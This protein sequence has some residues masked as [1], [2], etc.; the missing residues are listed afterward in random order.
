MGETQM[1][2]RSRTAEIVALVLILASSR[3][4]LAAERTIRLKD[5]INHEWSSELVNYD[6]VFEP[7]AC[8]ISTMTLEGPAGPVAFQLGQPKIDGDGNLI[9]ARLSFLTDLPAL[10][11]VVYKLG[12]DGRPRKAAALAAAD[13]VVNTSG[14]KT[15]FITKRA[16]VRLPGT[17]EMFDPPVAS[18]RVPAPITA[19]RT[20]EGKWIGAS[21]LFG[22]RKVSSFKTTLEATG[23]VFAQ[24]RLEYTYA[25]GDV[26]VITVRVVA[27]QEVVFI[28][29]ESVGHHPDD[30]WRLHLN[31]GFGNPTLSVLGEY[32]NNWGLKHTEVGHIKLADQL[33]ATIYNLVPWEDWWDSSTRTAFALTSPESTTAMALGSY[34]PAAWRHPSFRKLLGLSYEEFME[35]KRLPLV[36]SSDGS[37]YLQSASDIG[38]QKWYVGFL[39]RK[40][41]L[42]DSY[43]DARALHNSKYG[44]QTLDM[45]KEYVLDWDG[46]DDVQHPCVYVAP[47]NIQEARVKL[48]NDVDAMSG[49]F[50]RYYRKDNNE[51]WRIGGTELIQHMVNSQYWA[52]R[53]Q[54][55]N[56]A[57]PNR[58]DLMRHSLLLVN[59]YDL[60]MGT[61]KLSAPER[62]QLR[63]PIAFLGYT[64]NSPYVWD[65]DRAYT[66]DISNMHLSYVCNLGLTACAIPD[67]PMSKTWAK[68]A[69]KWVTIRLREHVGKNGVWRNENTHY[70][71][72]SLSSVLGFALGARNAG[73][74]DFLAQGEMRAAL[75]Y[76]E[77][78]LIP[79]DPRYK[80]RGL[81]PE[82]VAGVCERSAHSGIVAKALAT[83]DPEFSAEMQWA[84]NQQGNSTHLPNPFVRGF[85]NVLLDKS[86]PQATPRWKSESF[87]DVSVVLRNGLGTPDESYL[88]LSVRQSGNYYLSQPGG[89]TIYGRGKPLSLLFSSEYTSCTSED[90]LTNSVGL[91]RT[92]GNKSQR[93]TNRGGFGG[94]R[95]ERVS[96]LPRQDYVSAEFSL[97]GPHAIRQYFKEKIK[98]LS[99]PWPALLKTA[100]GTA[101]HKRQVLFVKGAGKGDVT[102]FILRDSVKGGQPTVWNMWSLSQKLGATRDTKNIEAFLA[103]APGARVTGASRLY[104][105]R[106]TAVGQFDV[107]TEY[108]VSL[109]EDTPRQTVR[110]GVREDEFQD[111]LHLQRTDDGDYF[112]ALFPR[113]RHE[114]APRFASLAAKQ[115]IKVSGAF[116][117][118]YCFVS[119]R[120]S[121]ASG[122]GVHFTGM[123]GTVQ[124]RAD[125]LVLA[126]ASRGA[127]SYKGH[128]LVAND[129]AS[130]TV[131]D[132][133]VVLAIARK[134]STKIVTTVSLPGGKSI[135]SSDGV[136]PVRM[137]DGSYRIVIPQGVHEV[138]LSR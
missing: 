64:L 114:A 103:D 127:V 118:D 51:R 30:G 100:S 113:R 37:L 13:L 28:E 24:A 31:K 98:P 134:G 55:T 94:G 3:S 46:A 53:Y 59:Q 99:S 33:P 62:K 45:V 137:D 131:K 130:M 69:V 79:W 18:S 12:Y 17:G 101:R 34:D 9:S 75:L 32:A 112:V 61:G 121:T 87:P 7:G 88:H 50:Y 65:I 124:D 11:E 22:N 77:K 82:Q 40:V 1:K 5:H 133:K 60:L 44:T 81:P 2:C 104:G 20:L 23:P 52:P 16:G 136:R 128:K 8:H 122:E 68:K 107:D 74:H 86:L 15:E 89:M 109:P 97:N 132:D 119:P 67:H 66:G 93:A 70:A 106:F 83:A 105:D 39:P 123:A 90:F 125:G 73:F 111:L 110:W 117:T 63:A 36:K 35:F 10:G 72:V 76:L 138:T 54:E 95:I 38:M 115:V 21:R 80:A 19:L 47:E 85:E 29:S 43:Q 6:L 58:F 126:L 78:Q 84:W 49:Q 56:E 42:D 96:A 92:P 129:A 91:A 41:D 135:R 48:G 71:R 27:G 120:R 4:C 26:S 108:Y 14:G 25:D 116:G 57:N 102:Y